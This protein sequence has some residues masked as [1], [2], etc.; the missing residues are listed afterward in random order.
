MLTLRRLLAVPL[1]LT[2]VWLLTILSIQTGV[3]VAAL[4]ALLMI[5]LGSVL[6]GIDEGSSRRSTTAA[7]AAL[8]L[9]AAA[10]LRPP[11]RDHPA[12]GRRR[13]CAHGS[14]GELVAFPGIRDRKAR[15]R[16]RGGVRRCHCR[17]V[18][19]LQGQRAHGARRCRGGAP[20]ERLRHLRRCSRTGPGP[21]LPISAY[22]QR[23]GR[24]GIPFNVVYG[25][26]APDGIV[27]PEL[28]T[29]ERV[30]QALDEALGRVS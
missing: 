20:T 27:L 11:G 26:A 18:H 2:A 10:I 16:G 4:V 7:V 12:D 29:K 22:L 9:V 1:V 19:H 8:S 24:Y 23:F 3:I 28:L 13:A 21:I 30:L 6:T 14:R 15:R 5:A 25:P 17:L